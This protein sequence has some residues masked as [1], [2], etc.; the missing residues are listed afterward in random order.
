MYFFCFFFLFNLLFLLLSYTVDIT[1]INDSLELLSVAIEPTSW[2][3]IT[4]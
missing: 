3:A 4:I 2:Y 1:R